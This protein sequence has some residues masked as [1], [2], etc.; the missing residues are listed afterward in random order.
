MEG[1]R[2]KI[3]YR[4]APK[5][6]QTASCP[7]LKERGS[8]GLADQRLEMEGSVLTEGSPSASRRLLR[9]NRPSTK[10]LFTR[11]TT[12]GE[13]QTVGKTLDR[14]KTQRVDA[15]WEEINIYID[16]HARVESLTNASPCSQ[17]GSIMRRERS[18]LLPLIAQ[19]GT[20]PTNV[21]GI[22]VRWHRPHAPAAEG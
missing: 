8:V 14:S 20:K 11:C 1:V 16:W 17:S 19:S 15:T 6:R 5:S 18:D 13:G 3:G 2:E 9:R 10:K 4:C 7:Q 21:P 22:L 12:T